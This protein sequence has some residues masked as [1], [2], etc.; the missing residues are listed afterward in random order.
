MRHW[1]IFAAALFALGMS[2]SAEAG[3]KNKPPKGDDTEQAS[4]DEAEGIVIQ[5]TGVADIDTLFGKAKAP[6][7]TITNTRLS[8]EKI[9][10]DLVTALGLTEGT[11]FADALADLM[12][13]GEGK[14]NLAVE[15]GKA[16]T[17]SAEEGIPANVQA[18]IDALNSGF[19][20]LMTVSAAL[21]QVPDQI[22]AVVDEAKTFA[23]VS[24]LTSM[25]LKPLEAPK[26]LKLINANLKALGKAPGEV[27]ELTASLSDM[28][29]TV[30]STFKSE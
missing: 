1:M 30:T 21:P 17:F 24:K 7:D 18:S 3:K 9:D 12:A 28:M 2:T 13:K 19:E 5:E 22:M 14:I 10:A 20:E 15:D 6:V 23:D 29:G 4:E 8:M 11:P 16:P 27:T 25:G 26:T